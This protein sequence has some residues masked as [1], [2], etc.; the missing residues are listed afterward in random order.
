VNRKE[1][2]SMITVWQNNLLAALAR[3][4]AGLEGVNLE[5]E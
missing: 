2:T 5:L 3:L 4:G 1:D